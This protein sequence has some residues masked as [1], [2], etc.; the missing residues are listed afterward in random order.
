MGIGDRTRW[1][2]FAD[3]IV[4]TNRVKREESS[5][6]QE[7]LRQLQAAAAFVGLQ[8]NVDKTECLAMGVCGEIGKIG[9]GL[10]EDVVITMRGRLKLGTMVDWSEREKVA[11]ANE[12]EKMD[13]TRLGGPP[14]H[15]VRTKH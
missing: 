11:E 4:V 1:L 9:E 13:L 6:A 3:D 15:V 5:T 10:E 12:L 2:A 14:T 8:V 7:A